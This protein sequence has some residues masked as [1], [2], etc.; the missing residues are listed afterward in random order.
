MSNNE[1]AGGS[2]VPVDPVEDHPYFSMLAGQHFGDQDE[3]DLALHD[4]GG[5]GGNK[6][7]TSGAG[8]GNE[9]TTSGVGD[10]NVTSG[11][12]AKRQRKERRPNKLSTIREEIM[13]VDPT[14]GLPTQPTSVAKGYDNNIGC[15]LREVININEED[16]RGKARN[17]WPPTSFRGF[18]HDTSSRN[19]TITLISRKIW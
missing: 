15:I 11:S 8:D 6:S 10:G 19:P 7:T 16:L 5:D 12:E 18:T 1:D 13:E 17:L 3:V 14:S 2:R 9:T 4:E